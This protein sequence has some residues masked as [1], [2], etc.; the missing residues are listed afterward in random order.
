MVTSTKLLF[1]STLTVASAGAFTPSSTIQTQTGIMSS[2]T[3]LQSIQ[4]N[5]NSLDNNQSTSPFSRRSLFQQTSSNTSKLLTLSSILLGSLSTSPQPSNARL[6]PVNNPS[7]LPSA[8]GEVVI[9]TEK[10]LTSG[11]VK[12]MSDL[13][14][15]LEKD[16]G[17]RLRVLCQNYPNTPGL[18]IRDYWDLGK[19]VRFGSLTFLLIAVYVLLSCLNLFL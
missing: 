10:F 14:N 5:E 13:I 18:A 3:L 15:S 11:Q 8:P 1:L 16:T 9:Q 12:R 7:L 17:F 2:S 4:N 6:D 19:D